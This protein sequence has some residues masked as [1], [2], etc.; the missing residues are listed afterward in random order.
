MLKTTSSGK[1]F[2][3]PSIATMPS[4]VVVLVFVGVGVATAVTGGVA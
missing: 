4:P 3:T 1:A 2:V